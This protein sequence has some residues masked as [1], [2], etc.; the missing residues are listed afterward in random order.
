VDVVFSFG[1]RVLDKHP[2]EHMLTFRTAQEIM[3]VRAFSAIAGLW[4]CTSGCGEAVV[5][6]LLV[7]QEFGEKAQ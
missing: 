2:F 5:V 6:V 3:H 7:A 4:R 1:R